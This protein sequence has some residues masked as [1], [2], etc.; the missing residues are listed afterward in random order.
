MT[1]WRCVYAG[2][3]DIEFKYFSGVR[4]QETGR[5]SLFRFFLCGFTSKYSVASIFSVVQTFAIPRTARCQDQ[6]SL[7]A[8]ESTGMQSVHNVSQCNTTYMAKQILTSHRFTMLR[9]S[10]MSSLVRIGV[11]LADGNYRR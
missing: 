6:T 5:L 11:N 3:R 4:N 7:K 8:A 10:M 9:D 2:K 1:F